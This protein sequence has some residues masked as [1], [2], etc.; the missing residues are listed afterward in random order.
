MSVMSKHSSAIRCLCKTLPAWYLNPQSSN[1]RTS[2]L[3]SKLEIIAFASFCRAAFSRIS[4]HI[5]YFLFGSVAV[6]PERQ[7]A[8][9]AAAL[10]LLVRRNS[11][12]QSL[13][14]QEKATASN[15][16]S[17]AWD[18]LSSQKHNIVREAEMNIQQTVLNSESTAKHLR[19]Q[20]A[21]AEA[22]LVKESTARKLAE[23]GLLAT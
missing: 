12:A 21:S 13:A 22:T 8:S 9:S 11:Q 1:A 15:I 2:F 16:E 7:M 20:L 18:A 3:H 5:L 14:E 17:Q 19:A 23:S 4:S 10:L 6:L